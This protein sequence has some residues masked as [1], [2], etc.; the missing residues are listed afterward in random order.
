MIKSREAQTG[1]VFEVGTLEKHKSFAAFQTAV[2]TN[3]LTVDWRAQEV[4]YRNSDG[5]QLQFR[6]DAKMS[7]NKDGFIWFAPDLW[8]NG[9]KRDISNWP[10]ADSP[11]VSLRDGVLKVAQGGASFMVDWSGELPRITK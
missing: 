1:F 4:R 10:I 3:P 7:E 9:K 8:I 2:R 5:D 11:V 6:Y